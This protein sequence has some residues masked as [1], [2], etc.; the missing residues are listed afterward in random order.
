MLYLLCASLGN[1]KCQCD[2]FTAVH[3][4]Q[5]DEGYTGNDCNCLLS[6]DTCRDPVNPEVG[7]YLSISKKSVTVIT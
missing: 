6:D 2:E 1:G 5:C 7:S 4:C 3:S